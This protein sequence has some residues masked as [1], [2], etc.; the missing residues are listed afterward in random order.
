[1]KKSLSKFVDFLCAWF[2]LI[3]IAFYFPIMCLVDG[4]DIV[5]SDD[6]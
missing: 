1:M 5:W 6:E 4:F 3:G 2:V